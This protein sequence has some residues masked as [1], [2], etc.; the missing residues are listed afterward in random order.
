MTFEHKIITSIEDIDSLLL[1]CNK[2][3]IRLVYSPDKI[4]EIPMQ[5]PNPPC[6]NT[7]QAT[8]APTVNEPAVPAH[9]KLLNVVR[10]IR[11]QTKE[12]AVERP[13]DRGGF[14]VLF[15]FEAP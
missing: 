12:K 8:V 1:E 3:H 2:C 5:C 6:H 4:G 11:N 9:V 15:Q 10:L 13:S 7:W 14:T